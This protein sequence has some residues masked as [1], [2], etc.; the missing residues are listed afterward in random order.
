MSW[1][2]S[3]CIKMW[4][5]MVKWIPLENQKR[6]SDESLEVWHIETFTSLECFNV[7][8]C[9]A[10][11]LQR[12]TFW[13]PSFAV[14][15]ALQTEVRSCINLSGWDSLA[16]IHATNL[17]HVCPSSIKNQFVA[18]LRVSHTLFDQIFIHWHFICQKKNCSTTYAT[19][20]CT[21]SARA[22]QQHWPTIYYFPC[23][24]HDLSWSNV[25]CMTVLT[26]W[27]CPFSIIEAMLCIGSGWSAV[28]WTGTLH[29]VTHTHTIQVYQSCSYYSYKPLV[30]SRKETHHWRELSNRWCWWR[31]RHGYNLGSCSFNGRTLINRLTFF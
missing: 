28:G 1:N 9:V 10:A 5:S 20:V 2:L 14:W 23:I 22:N 7:E 21:S 27:W 12:G 3:K 18:T 25:R 31:I 30:H 29:L 24:P 17:W 13:L 26:V 16:Q 6:L 8:K 11:V 15:G 19:W 4:F